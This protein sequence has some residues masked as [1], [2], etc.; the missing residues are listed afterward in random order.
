[1]PARTTIVATLLL[2]TGASATCEP[3]AATCEFTL[4]IHKQLTGWAG[5]T[6]FYTS[7]GIHVDKDG[8]PVADQS[9]G[10]GADGV[11]TSRWVIVANGTLP[12]PAIEVY[13]GQEVVVNVVNNDHTETVSVHWHG[14]YQRGTPWMDGVGRLTQ[15]SI[16]P[17]QTFTY[18]FTAHP[19]GTH[20]YHSHVGEQRSHGLHGAFIVREPTQDPSTEH[21]ILMED[22]DGTAGTTRTQKSMK[23]F[24]GQGLSSWEEQSTSTIL[25]GKGRAYDE[26]TGAYNEAPLSVF[27]VSYTHLTLP[28]KA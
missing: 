14:I 27:A 9:L 19:V 5:W 20:W 2:V 7:N 28:T 23:T 17:G 26:A 25:N 4:D 1:M 24:S 6:K 11:D 13:K 8:T 22:Y 12:G 16:L 21:V 3:T 15:C 18:R 10:I